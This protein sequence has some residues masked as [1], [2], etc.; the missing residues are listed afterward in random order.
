M[1]AVAPDAGRTIPG[2]LAAAIEAIEGIDPG[3]T[4]NPVVPEALVANGF[5]ACACR[6]RPADSAA[7]WSRPSTCWPRSAQSADRP[8]SGLRCTPTSSEHW[9]NRT[10]GRPSCVPG[11]RAWWW[12]RAHCSTRPRFLAGRI[13]RAFRG[14]RGGLINPPL[15]DIAHQ[16]FARRLVDDE[17]AWSPR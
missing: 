8:R 6:S 16:G 10:P 1:L 4:Y 17:R 2:R 7:A 9:S 5:I 15:D 3:D 14:A 12:P 11:S 13:E